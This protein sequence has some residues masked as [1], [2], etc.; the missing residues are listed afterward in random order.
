M[1]RE[2]EIIAARLRRAVRLAAGRGRRLECLGSRQP[3]PFDCSVRP[4]LHSLGGLAC[5]RQSGSCK[6]SRT[7][8]SHAHSK[9]AAG[10]GGDGESFIA[11]ALRA[12]FVP[13]TSE[14]DR[15]AVAAPVEKSSTASPVPAAHRDRPTTR[16]ST[17]PTANTPSSRIKATF[18][19]SRSTSVRSVAPTGPTMG[20]L[21]GFGY[22][23]PS[24]AGRGF[25][26]RVMEGTMPLTVA[27]DIGPI[28]Q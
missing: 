12:R 1:R 24:C 7:Q 6:P 27:A 22:C 3:A 14:Q 15:S 19:V 28:R 2:R 5:T 21:P 10:V 25:V 16:L 4:Q 20:L 17:I 13:R 23:G 26:R 9:L 8:A 11:C 18:H